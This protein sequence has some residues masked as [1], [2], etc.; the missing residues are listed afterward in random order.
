MLCEGIICLSKKPYASPQLLVLKQGNNEFRPS[1]DFRK[2]NASTVYDH[3]PVLHK[4]DFTFEIRASS[5]FLMSVTAKAYNQIRVAEEVCYDAVRVIRIR[6]N[7]F[8]A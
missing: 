8:W 2:L 3:Y 4:H 5:V 7:N 1:V 6:S